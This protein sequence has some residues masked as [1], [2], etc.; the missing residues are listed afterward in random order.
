MKVGVR[1]LIKVGSDFGSKLG[2][3][4]RFGMF[5]SDRVFVSDRSVCFGVF[6]SDREVVFCVE[7]SW[8]VLEQFAQQN[9]QFAPFFMIAVLVVLLSAEPCLARVLH[10]FE[11]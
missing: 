9:A 11:A 8:A 5:V 3:E 2:S 4:F 10:S 7:N 6:V 1:I